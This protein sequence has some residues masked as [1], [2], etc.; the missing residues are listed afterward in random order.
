MCIRDS[1]P[2]GEGSFN[3][4]LASMLGQIDLYFIWHVILV[5]LGAR[6]SS[7]LPRGKTWLAVLIVFAPVSYTHLDVYKRQPERWRCGMTF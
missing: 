2:T 4:F 6:L 1:A 7:R 5:Y 3:V